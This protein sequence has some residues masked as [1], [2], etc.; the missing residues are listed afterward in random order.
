MKEVVASRGFESFLSQGFVAEMIE[1]NR[2]VE[3]MMMRKKA[4]EMMQM[5]E[6]LVWS[7]TS[8]A[9]RLL[10]GFIDRSSELC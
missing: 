10:R 1:R 3:A 4:L 9:W 2:V 6:R 7:S 5:V 8:F